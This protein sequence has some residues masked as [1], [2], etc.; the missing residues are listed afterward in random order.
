[1]EHFIEGVHNYCDR[2]CERCV[3]TDRCRVFYMEEK[4]R[5]ISAHDPKWETSLEPIT[6][7]LEEAKIMLEKMAN[8]KGIDLAETDQEFEKER[9]DKKSRVENHP[10]MKKSMDYLELS[11]EW[12][13]KGQVKDNTDKIFQEVNLGIKS[14]QEG[15]REILLLRDS[16]EVIRW[17]QPLIAAKCHRA[18]LGKED[19]YNKHFAEEERDYNGSAKIARIAIER[20][21]RAWASLLGFFEEEESAIFRILASL[22]QAQQVLERAFPNMDHFIRPGFD[23]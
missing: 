12:L 6:K 20:S 18:L 22:Q 15:E 17:Y 7:T 5:K 13:E 14:M 4:D 3:F 23:E 16:L 21:M 9:A 19:E 8:E 1:M 10:L 2:W 11:G